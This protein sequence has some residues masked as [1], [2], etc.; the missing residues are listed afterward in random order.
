MAKIVY[1]KLLYVH[2]SD[3]DCNLIVN[4]CASYIEDWLRIGQDRISHVVLY[5]H[6]SLKDCAHIVDDCALVIED[7]PG[8]GQDCMSYMNIDVMKIA[9][10]LS[11]IVNGY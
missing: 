6:L 2:F 9:I 4:D 5:V 1:L 11:M 3:E 10:T 7:W 8:I